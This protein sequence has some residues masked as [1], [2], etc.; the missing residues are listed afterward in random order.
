LNFTDDSSELCSSALSRI[1]TEEDVPCYF[2]MVILILVLIVSGMA[3]I[4]YYA[5]GISYLDDNTKKNHVIS[6]IGVIIAVKMIGILF[7]YILSWGCLRWVLRV[8]FIK[9]H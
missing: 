9:Y 6:F 2:T 5:L 1:I 8:C 3:N 7:G 4:T